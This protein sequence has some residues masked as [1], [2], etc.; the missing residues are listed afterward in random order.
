M[1]LW[2]VRFSYWCTTRHLSSAAFIML[3]LCCFSVRSVNSS[4]GNTHRL[5]L[6]A[7]YLHRCSML[8]VYVSEL[9]CATLCSL[10]YTSVRLYVHGCIV[11]RQFG[12]T[13]FFSIWSFSICIL[14]CYILSLSITNNATQ[15]I[16]IYFGSEMI[17]NTIVQFAANSMWQ[18]LIIIWY[19]EDDK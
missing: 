14:D 13:M 6:L 12:F 4:I 16:G 18:M 11:Q 5:V 9:C 15:S 1:W 19:I 17:N 3:I 7:C 10:V 8:Y 2:T